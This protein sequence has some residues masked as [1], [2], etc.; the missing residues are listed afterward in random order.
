MHDVYRGIDGMK[1]FCESSRE[2]YMKIIK[3]RKKKI[4]IIKK[5]TTEILSKYKNLLYQ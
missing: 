5:P 1:K 4:E 2:H 3:F